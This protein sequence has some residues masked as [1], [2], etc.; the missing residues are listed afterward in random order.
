MACL[1]HNEPRGYTVPDVPGNVW[2]DLQEFVAEPGRGEFV[3]PVPST[4]Y[5]ECKEEIEARRQAEKVRDVY[6]TTRC[7]TPTTMFL[8]VFGGTRLC[9]LVVIVVLL[10]CDTLSPALPLAP[11][12]VPRGVY[13][14]ASLLVFLFDILLTAAA[15]AAAVDKVFDVLLVLSCRTGRSVP[16]PPASSWWHNPRARHFS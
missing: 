3:H 8:S 13:A 9:N 14:E 16:I 2:G 11:R 7:R 6:G 4:L 15:A 1:I 5:L 12:C 10:L